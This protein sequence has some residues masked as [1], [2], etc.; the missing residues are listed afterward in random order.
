MAQVNEER[1]SAMI[2]ICLVDDHDIVRTGLRMVLEKEKD[3]E[4]VGEMADGE[5]ALRQ[6]RKLK[7]DVVLLDLSLPGISGVEVAR[8]LL[9]SQPSLGIIALTSMK[10]VSFPKMLIELGARGYIIK[11]NPADEVI[12][13]IR[14]VAGGGRY[15]CQEIAQKIAEDLMS[16]NQSPFDELSARE[17]EVLLLAL[18]GMKPTAIAEELSLSPKTVSTYRHRIFEKLGVE[19][20]VELMKLAM[21]HGL[22]SADG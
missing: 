6:V 8:K 18:K 20:D 14:K 7:P 16:G 2:R 15:I 21:E 12:Q 13:A 1:G 9:Q 11:D 17:L 4:V 5:T 10:K 3:F 19:T 22:I